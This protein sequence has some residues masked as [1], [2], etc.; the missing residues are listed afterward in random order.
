M[1]AYVDCFSGISGDMTLAAFVDL[2]VP[3][4]FLHDSIGR[5]LPDED[6]HIEKSFAS[7]NGIQAIS[8]VVDERKGTL[9]RDYTAI[10]SLLNT[11]DI[12]NPVKEMSLEIFSRIA[13]AEAKIHGCPIDKVHFHEVGGVDAIVD[14]VGT[15]FCVEFL[16]L[17][18][19]TASKI[20]LG[21]GFVTCSHGKLPLPAPATMEILKNIPVRGTDIQHELVT[22]T[23]AAIIATLATAFHGMPDMQIEQIGYGAGKWDTGEIPNLL[24]IITGKENK[25]TYGRTTESVLVLETCI[26]DMNPEIFGFLM[27]RLFEDGAL[28]VYWVPVYMKKNRPGTMIQ[29]VCHEFC[30]EKIVDRILMETT[31]SGVRFYESDRYTLARR[32]IEIDTSFGRI[33]VKQITKPD[34]AKVIVPEYEVCRDIAIEKK[35]PVRVVYD[36]VYRESLGK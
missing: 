16:N 24:R 13:Q 34:G 8:I 7:R 33:Q 12:P 28:D 30:R 6:F 20:P 2:G 9:A 26:D 25:D 18:T 29:V 11:S 35:I 10:R 17:S 21:S 27:E 31:T 1:Y 5:V 36:T 23:G 14:I 19:I 3:I 32:S 22:P 4:S 15:S